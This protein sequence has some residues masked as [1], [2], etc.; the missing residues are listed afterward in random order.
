VA[1]TEITEVV[2]TIGY[3]C[4]V[5][6]IKGKRYQK[7]E[8]TLRVH[9]KTSA[10]IYNTDIEYLPGLD[11]YK[12]TV[13]KIDNRQYIGRKPHT[14]EEVAERM[15]PNWME[16]VGEKVYPTVYVEDLPRVV[17]KLVVTD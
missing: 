6:G 10:Y 11:L 14:I 4:R 15:N 13:N 8:R 12:V 1:V 16:V 2:Q 3:Q 5:L 9:H 17:H 7:D